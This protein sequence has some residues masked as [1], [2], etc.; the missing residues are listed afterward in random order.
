MD[1][2][3]QSVRQQYLD[4]AEGAEAQARQDHA[5]AD[6]MIER[7]GETTESSGYYR[8]RAEWAEQIERSRR[9]TAKLFGETDE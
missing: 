5:T 6:A 3:D 7:D 4:E 9:E 1:T 8:K 2:A